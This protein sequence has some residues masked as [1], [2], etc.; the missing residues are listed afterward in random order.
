MLDSGVGEQ[1]LLGGALLSSS[2]LVSARWPAELIGNVA[3]P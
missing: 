3:T 2:I 1:L